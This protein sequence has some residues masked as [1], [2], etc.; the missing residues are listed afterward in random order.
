MTNVVNF[1][2]HGWLIDFVEFPDLIKYYSTI[3]NGTLLKEEYT[4]MDNGTLL[5]DIENFMYFT[6]DIP[7]KSYTC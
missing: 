5:K 6:E 3:V 2:S 4:T 7:A 1:S